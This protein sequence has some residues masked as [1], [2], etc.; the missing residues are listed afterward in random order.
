MEAKQMITKP[1]K[2]FLLPPFVFPASAQLEGSPF[3]FPPRKK[4][5][6]LFLVSAC[7]LRLG[8]N[9]IQHLRSANIER[10]LG[11]QPGSSRP[12]GS[13]KTSTAQ[14]G[15]SLYDEQMYVGEMGE[16]EQNS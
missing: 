16:E 11:G 13:G 10:L 7:D 12:W 4:K 8:T 15:G 9:C 6:L 5:S 3:C 1:M 2:R 14:A